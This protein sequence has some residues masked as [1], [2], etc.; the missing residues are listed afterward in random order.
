MRDI[1][2]ATSNPHKFREL[3]GLLKGSGIR[4]R[5]LAEFPSL[6]PVKE[7]GRTFEANAV[8]KATAIARSTGLLTLADDSGIEVDALDGAPGI[9]SARFAGAH[10]N[11]AANNQKLLRLLDGLSP[12]R[13]GARYVC[14]LALA[15]PTRLLQRTRGS[16]R[17]RIAMHPQGH[18]GFGYDPIF[19]LPSRGKTIAQLPAAMKR[20]LSH[21]ACAAR[22]MRRL[23]RSFKAGA[24]HR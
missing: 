17:G 13:R 22:R 10:G 1:V 2:I 15:S 9:R 16:W 23:L 20:R 11:D 3:T 19:L 12:R 5:S 6:A 7:N 18:R 4:W 14:V 21:R 24:P 8:K